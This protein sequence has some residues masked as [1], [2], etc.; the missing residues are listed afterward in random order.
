M[1]I[2]FPLK[3]PKRTRRL[4]PIVLL[5]SGKNKSSQHRGKEDKAVLAAVWKLP[6][7]AADQEGFGSL[8][9]ARAIAWHGTGD[10]V[11][12]ST[13]WIVLLH[14]PPQVKALVGFWEVSLHLPDC[15]LMLPDNRGISLWS[16]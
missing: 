1:I 5:H 6:N 16:F 13:C 8:S 10:S 14:R 11:F 2:K 15:T 4:F 7:F 12:L 9:A 3:Q